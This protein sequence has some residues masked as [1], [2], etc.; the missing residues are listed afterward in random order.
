MSGPCIPS[1]HALPRPAPPCRFVQVVCPVAVTSI[2]L[3]NGLEGFMSTNEDP[4]NPADPEAQQNYNHAAI[5]VG[6]R[7]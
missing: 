3:G 2:L 6:A 7:S 4:N 5:Q 1:I